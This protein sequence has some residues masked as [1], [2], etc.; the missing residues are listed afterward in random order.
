MDRQGHEGKGRESSWQNS[1]Y[2][3][4]RKT[5]ADTAPSELARRWVGRRSCG[6]DSLSLAGR[7]GQG[8][9][10]GGWRA[11]RGERVHV[12][13]RGCWRVDR[14]A[15]RVAWRLLLNLGM[16]CKKADKAYEVKAKASQ[17]TQARNT[18]HWETLTAGV[19]TSDQG[20]CFRA[21]GQEAML[22]NCEANR[23]QDQKT[24][25]PCTLR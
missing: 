1:A 22:R 10:G 6:H 12:G 15:R 18:A 11:P 24:R 14:R 2:K 7:G 25:D 5:K 23:L 19:P 21:K 3:A 4:I 16:A 9:R 17:E 13:G 20:P 8:W